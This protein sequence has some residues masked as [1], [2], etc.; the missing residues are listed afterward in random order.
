MK[1]YS[2]EYRSTETVN[3]EKSEALEF[4]FDKEYGQ[5]RWQVTDD[6]WHLVSGCYEFRVN[7][8]PILRKAMPNFKW[9]FHDLLKKKNT[10]AAL[11]ERVVASDFFWITSVFY[12]ELITA[13]RVNSLEKPFV[14]IGHTFQSM[15]DS[16]A[17]NSD[18]MIKLL[19]SWGVKE[20]REE[21]FED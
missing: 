20:D 14:I 17:H 18:G 21:H 19:Q 7:P 4:G 8:L 2:S 5:Q 11:C 12:D 6:I 9:E 3:H 10:S 16:C 13:R 15:R 1:K